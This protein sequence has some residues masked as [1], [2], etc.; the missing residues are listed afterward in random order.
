MRLNDDVKQENEFVLN[1]GRK[2]KNL[3]DLV[4][5]LNTMDEATFR[6][7]VS[8]SRNDFHNWV[9]DV[10]G[11][12]KFARKLL[13]AETR[14]EMRYK[15]QRRVM[16]INIPE[17]QE[18]KLTY[19][20]Q[21]ALSEVERT[22][23]RAA[24]QKE[25]RKEAKTKP[26][27]LRLKQLKKKN[28]RKTAKKAKRKPAK[29]A[30]KRK[31]AAKKAAGKAKPG[32]KTKRKAAKHAAGKTKK[33]ARRKPQAASRKKAAKRKT[34][35][36]AARKTPKK[37]KA[38]QR[39]PRPTTHHPLPAANHKLQAKRAKPRRKTRKKRGE[40]NRHIFHVLKHHV[41]RHFFGK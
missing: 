2:L 22:E 37:K 38:K 33:T 16:E 30:K 31:A 5:A 27:N 28:T 7:H 21:T 41:M 6:H 34:T 20:P 3:N 40:K 17:K 18:V 9:R 1:D 14:S 19:M 23:P 8:S 10:Y 24:P 29:K 13:A 15:L 36:H 12:R 4:T 35:K 32:I 11:D 26:L 25:S 39:K